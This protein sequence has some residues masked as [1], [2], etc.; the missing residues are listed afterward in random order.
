MSKAIVVG[1]GVIGLSVALHLRERGW[2]V[3]VV[4]RSSAAWGCSY[5]NAG[6]LVPNH[7]VP[8]AAPGRL[9][10][11]L[12]RLLSRTA[13]VSLALP[14]T[15]AQL[16]WLA[17]LRRRATTEHVERSAGALLA[18]H[19]ES[20]RLY[21]AWA[22]RLRLSVATRG[23][24]KVY[25]TPRG[26]REE[27]ENAEMARRLGLEA[28]AMSPREMRELDPHLSFAATGAVWYPESGNL[29]PVELMS[30][31]EEAL[32]SRGAT[33]LRGL[34]V[35]SI[36]EKGGEV[37]G[38]E[39]G[40]GRLEA[41]EYVLASG[42][43][44]SALLSGLGVRLPLLAGKGYSFELP[45]PGRTVPALLNEEAVA[46]APMGARL[47]FAGTMEIG[48]LNDR[49]E[50]RR[51]SAMCASL[52]RTLPDLAL[53]STIEQANVGL[54]PLSADGLPSIG[55]VAGIRA[56]SVAAGHGMMGV[57]LA[58]ATAEALAAL[59]DGERGP[60]DLEPF[61]PDRFSGSR[62]SRRG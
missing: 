34:E 46:V 25:H 11:A 51:L 6:F 56:L 55:R 39:A 37:R 3:T 50:R 12:R 57:S 44:T 31:L 52:R 10:G 53:P 28:V 18:L 59:L 26:E 33:I 30:G 4:E 24:L 36:E 9:R 29:D 16:R 42:L 32:T 8:L 7:F 20:R 5:V 47:R 21:L 40:G 2:E 61:D 14:R 38:L 19:R 54:R 43:W 35:D 62:L 58:A 15:W 49:V 60:V 48:A 1:A 41:D 23:L 27:L 17:E 22:E 45:N 13:P